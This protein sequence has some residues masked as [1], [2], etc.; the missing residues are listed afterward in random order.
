MT[1]ANPYALLLLLPLAF[2]AWRMLRRSR[3]RG[4]KFSAVSRIP[5]KTASWRVFC[6][7]LAPYIAI[8]GMLLLVLA[9]ARPRIPLGKDRK[10]VD[11]IAIAMVVDVSGSMSALDLTPKGAEYSK[12]TTRLSVVKKVFADFVEK[13]PDDLI[14]LVTF[15]TYATA[16]TPLTSDHKT[17]LNVLKGVEIPMG[18]GEARTAIGDGL[19]VGL[20]RIKEAK[21]KSKIVILLS[22]GD[23]NVGA[24]DGAVEPELAIEAAVK[25]GIK[26]YTIGV[27]TKAQIVPSLAID[28]SGRN[29]VVRERSGFDEALLKNIAAATSGMYFAVNDRDG[30]EMA[31]EE[32][33]KLETTP[34]E[35][36]EWKRWIEYFPM[37]LSFGASLVFLSSLLSMLAVRRLI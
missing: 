26:V 25:L 8:L 16:R 11:A 32:I 19:S 33:D 5:V 4:L 12:D 18:D 22:D 27:G 13:R 10:N 31:L 14:S 29:I 34:L 17:L 1:F 35:V 9:C 36:D 2:A 20:L 21:P 23:C 3:G 28:Y 15:G 37:L 7:S 24:A 6:A 30:L